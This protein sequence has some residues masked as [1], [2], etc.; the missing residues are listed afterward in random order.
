MNERKYVTNADTNTTRLIFLYTQH[1]SAS[2][3]PHRTTLVIM[4]SFET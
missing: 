1:T 2:I 3:N 4:E